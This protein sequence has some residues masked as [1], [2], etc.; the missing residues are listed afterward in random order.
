METANLKFQIEAGHT[1][2]SAFSFPSLASLLPFIR[3]TLITAT[4]VRRLRRAMRQDAAVAA[5]DRDRLLCAMVCH[6]WEHVPFYRE[7]WGGAGFDPTGF[8]GR[9]DLHRIPIS[10]PVE[11]KA[12]L[13]AG[14]LLPRGVRPE[15]CGYL[16][17]SGSSSGVASRYYRGVSEERIR[18]AVGLQIWREHG[19]GWQHSTAQFQIKPG[20]QHILQRF[21]VAPKTWIGSTL[22]TPEQ[23]QRFIRSDADVVVG[24]ATSLRRIA[25]AIEMSGQSPAKSPRLVICAG[26]LADQTTRRLVRRVLGTEIVALY[27]MTE[28]GYVAFQCECRGAMHVNPLSHVVEVIRDSQP[29]AGGSIGELVITD[30]H[31]KTTP[32]IRYANGDLATAAG[33]PCPCGR[34]APPIAA[35]EGRASGCVTLPDGRLLTTR[36]IVD[37]MAEVVDIGQYRIRQH[38]LGNFTIE[39]FEELTDARRQAIPAR[40]AALTGPANI[41][42]SSAPAPSTDG[43]GKTQSVISDV[44]PIIRA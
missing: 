28:V 37:H 27:G 21:G 9:C 11:I 5:R 18:R 39:F 25:R 35:V 3:E 13:A 30:L 10:R 29:V 38:A 22:P 40:L 19:F 12:A 36:Q 7:H 15:D 31:S 20:S 26:E 32:L 41:A 2:A 44:P 33:E 1:R 8:R 43:T 6:A 14:R 4:M 42:I 23:L 17:S 24:T 34:V 16:E